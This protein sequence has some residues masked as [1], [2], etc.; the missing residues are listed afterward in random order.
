[1]L[2]TRVAASIFVVAGLAI[3][4]P[5]YGDPPGQAPLPQLPPPTPRT[6]ARAPAPKR[7]QTQGPVAYARLW[8]QAPA[9]KTAPVDDA[10][11]PKLVL[12]GLNVPDRVELSA[13]TERGGFS[14]EDLDHAAHLMR[15]HA[16]NEHPIDPRLLDLVYRVQTHFHAPE[17]RVLSGYRTP[18]HGSTSN[19]G[20]G[21]AC[22]MVV[23]GVLDED[24]A[25][26]ARE[27]GFVG[28]GVYPTSGFVHLDIRDRSFFWID[29]SGPGKRS[30]L[31]GV[32]GDV[33][34]RSDAQAT[35]RGDKPVV[36]FHIA[37]DVDATLRGGGA[38]AQ[39]DT[40]DED[41]DTAVQ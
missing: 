32:L 36:P 21:R 22:D 29:T 6:A 3:A 20:K 38:A 41:A 37:S 30:R 26:F 35:A 24:V 27:Q 17:I 9:G 8:H 12:Q 34:A 14:A 31:R 2:R 5:S 25:K 11:K 1:M 28:V 16:G 15:D 7:A 23:P 13:R 18:H 39:S 40:D 10:G 4:P 33:A 19:H